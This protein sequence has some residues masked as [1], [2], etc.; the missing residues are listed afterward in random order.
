MFSFVLEHH[1]SKLS[2]KLWCQGGDTEETDVE[3]GWKWRSLAQ[4]SL[5]SLAD[6]DTG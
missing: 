1:Q 6:M 5:R 3:I 4:Y 2:S